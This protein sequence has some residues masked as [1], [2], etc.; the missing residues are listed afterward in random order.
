MLV[1][2][3]QRPSSP[4]SAAEILTVAGSGRT[5]WTASRWT[6]SRSSGIAFVPGGDPHDVGGDS[7]LDPSTLLQ[8]AEMAMLA[9]EGQSGAAADLPAEHGRGLPAPVPAGH[10]VPAG[11]E[12]GRIIVHYQP[13]VDLAERELIGVEALVRW[14]HPE[15]GLVSPAE[16]VEAIEAT[17]SIDILLGH[18]LDI[19]LQQLRDW[20]D[21]G[22]PDHRG[23]EPLG[24][25]PARRGLPDHGRASP[26]SAPTCRPS[27]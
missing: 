24:A 17:G 23:G 4:R 8:R 3:S 14:M 20:I 9:A 13:K 22:H 26:C 7:G 19:V 21:A 25:Q 15:F 12:Q 27:C 5:R 2:A 10:P 6:R 16:F 11:V 1:D 18:V